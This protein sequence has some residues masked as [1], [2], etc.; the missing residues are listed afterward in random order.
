MNLELVQQLNNC[1]CDFRDLTTTTIFLY[2]D[3]YGVDGKPP[4]QLADES[5]F[6]IECCFLG[7]LDEHYGRSGEN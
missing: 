2:Y 7:L 3:Y 1:G 6:R 5:R 4:T